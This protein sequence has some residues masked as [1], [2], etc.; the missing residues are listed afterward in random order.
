MYKEKPVLPFF[1][2]ERRFKPPTTTTNA[3]SAISYFKPQIKFR[4]N[5][6]LFLNGLLKDIKKENIQDK[7][8]KKVENLEELLTEP[9]KLRKII[10][11][12]R[13]EQDINVEFRESAKRYSDPV[14][15]DIMTQLI[16]RAPPRQGSRAPQ[17]QR[18]QE[19]FKQKEAPR[20]QKSEQEIQQEEAKT[21]QK[22]LSQQQAKTQ[23]EA[24]LELSREDK[25]RIRQE[26]GLKSI[27]KNVKQQIER[28]LKEGLTIGQIT[29]QLKTQQEAPQP[30]KSQQK[31]VE[32]AGGAVRPAGGRRIK[33]PER[34]PFDFQSF[35]EPQ[36]PQP[37]EK[38]GRGRPKASGSI[39]PPVKQSGSKIGKD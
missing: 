30:I 22:Q 21:Q 32:L 14:F 38:R 3:N 15:E 9:A 28:Q 24:I 16:K 8:I 1:T 12:P 17:K 34:P 27:G 37:Q 35:F 6:E 31:L 11:Q 10:L 4:E 26:T 25:A 13:T 7:I 23:Q 2:E 36:P 5:P 18:P 39:L 19:E 29:Q 20:P 33:T